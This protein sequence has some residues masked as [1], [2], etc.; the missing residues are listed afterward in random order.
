MI[1]ITTYPPS[2][3]LAPFVHLLWTS[4]TKDSLAAEPITTPPNGCVL[5]TM[6]TDDSRYMVKFENS[7]FKITPRA[8]LLGQHFGPVITKATRDETSTIG[9]MF[10]SV[11]F[12]RLYGVDMSALTQKVSD[13]ENILGL[14]VTLL[15][16]EIA[17]VQ[18]DA[19]RVEAV[20]KFLENSVSK[21][22]PK[23]TRTESIVETMVEHRGT[24][25]VTDIAKEYQVT[26]RL[27]EKDF[28]TQIGI[29]PK[30]FNRIIQFNA[31]LEILKYTPEIRW[32]ELAIRAGYYDQAHL[33][34][35]F[36]EFTGR[37]PLRHVQV[38]QT[39]TQTHLAKERDSAII[40]YSDKG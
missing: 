6:F 27:I 21:I 38:D 31:T 2:A 22:V 36:Q 14:V 19:L 12:H 30:Y 28:R 29:S 26:T 40:N 5:L 1:R 34:K 35:A 7:D 8:A 23:K 25:S 13:A 39:L 18:N 20:T 9:I 4:T 11:A 3:L 16:D 15:M 24:K 37:S 17:S 33:I 32:A 10:K